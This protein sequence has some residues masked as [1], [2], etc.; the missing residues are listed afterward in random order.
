[1]QKKTRPVLA[2]SAAVLCAT[3]LAGPKDELSGGFWVRFGSLPGVCSPADGVT[4][5]ADADG[6]LTLT[7][8]ARPE[9][10]LGDLRFSAGAS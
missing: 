8:K 9:E 3:L 7:F 1:M 6:K 4:C 10:I 2:L 5:A